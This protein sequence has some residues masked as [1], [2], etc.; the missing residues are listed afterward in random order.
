MIA[1]S[2]ITFASFRQFLADLG[3]TVSRRGKFWRFEHAS[4]DTVCLF[5]PYRERERVTQI[6]IQST[7]RQLDLRGVM[8]EKAFDER[9]PTAS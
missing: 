4:S 1:R 5:R 7:R 8:E 6:D 2:P 9:I 3:F